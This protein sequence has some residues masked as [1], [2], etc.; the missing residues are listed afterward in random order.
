MWGSIRNSI[1]KGL[2]GRQNSGFILLQSR[3]PPNDNDPREAAGR[4][5]VRSAG[6]S[7]SCLNKLVSDCQQHEMET[8]Y[9]RILEDAGE[10]GN[11]EL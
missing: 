9:R 10:L 2:E 6:T 4:G 3:R 1:V 7:S 8:L 11:G 5:R